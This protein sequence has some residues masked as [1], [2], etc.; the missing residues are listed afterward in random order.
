MA[1]RSRAQRRGHHRVPRQWPADPEPCWFIALLLKPL[2]QSDRTRATEPAKEF[3]RAMSRQR[4]ADHYAENQEGYIHCDCHTVYSFQYS[5][6]REQ[7]EQCNTSAIPSVCLLL[8]SIV[9]RSPRSIRK[10]QEEKRT[11][12]TRS[13]VL[14]LAFLTKPRIYQKIGFVKS[15]VF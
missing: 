10:E 3:L 2:T 6:S 5:S 8:R 1:S 4:Q 12:R 13:F 11:N 15:V 9:Y 14:H 7:G